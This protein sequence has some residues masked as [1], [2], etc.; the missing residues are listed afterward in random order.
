MAVVQFSLILYTKLTCLEGPEKCL[1]KIL[2]HEQTLVS[3]YVG[4][5]EF[6]VAAGSSI[7]I[8]KHSAVSALKKHSA[9]SPWSFKTLF[10]FPPCSF[11]I[12]KT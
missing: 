1:N 4:R 6:D 11:M 10:V 8:S 9:V 2:Q 3:R 7:A 5:I 12:P